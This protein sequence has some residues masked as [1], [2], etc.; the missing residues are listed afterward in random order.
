MEEW[1]SGMALI[2]GGLGVLILLAWGLDWAWKE[3]VREVRDIWHEDERSKRR[4]RG[5][6]ND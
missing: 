6:K 2:A 4:R 3:S 1:W 5:R